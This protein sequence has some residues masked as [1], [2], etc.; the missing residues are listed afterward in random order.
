MHQFSVLRHLS[1][2]L[3]EKILVERYPDLQAMQVSCH[4]AHKDEQSGPRAALR[5]VREV[6]PHRGHAHGPGR[7]PQALR[8]HARPRSKTC[9]KEV[10]GPQG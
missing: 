7:R 10:H 5:Q 4:A 3:I 8:L 6:P 1:E 2:L 9:L